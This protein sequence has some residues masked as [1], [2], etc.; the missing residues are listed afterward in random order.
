[1]VAALDRRAL[2]AALPVMADEPVP[3]V[4]GVDV[5][6]QQ[7]RPQRRNL[8]G[9]FQRDRR[10]E[11]VAH[12]AVVVQ[13]EAE[14]VAVAPEQP[15]EGSVVLRVGEDHLTVVAAA[16]QVEAGFA[17]PLEAVRDARYRRLLGA[18]PIP[19]GPNSVAI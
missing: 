4:A 6:P 18:V 17:G 3:A 10:M 2:E 12:Q 5:G 1:L 14:S 8:P 9:V 19:S 11:G 7:P 13:A 16:H 15:Q